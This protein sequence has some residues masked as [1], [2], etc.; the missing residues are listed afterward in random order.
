MEK[1]NLWAP[2]RI[3]Y[4]L[5][6]DKNK[7]CF[8]CRAYKSVNERKHFVLIREK[9]VFVVMNIFPYNNGHLLISPGRHVK[10][11]ES[12]TSEENEAIFKL[13]KNSIRILKKVLKPQGFNI[14]LNLGSAAGAGLENHIHLHVVPRWNGDTNFMPVT[15]GIKVIPQSINELYD[16]LLKEFSGNRTNRKSSA[17]SQ[18]QVNK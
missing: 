9:S 4:I 3:G 6:H 10:N 12:L 13:L 7:G 5:Q 15:S 11:Y 8:L 16:I 2:W 18:K 1:K 17:K 14:G